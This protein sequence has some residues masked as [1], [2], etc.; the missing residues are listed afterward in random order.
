MNDDQEEKLHAALAT[1]PDE[2][3]RCFLLR[4]V[5]GF[6]ETEIAVLMKLRIETVRLRLFQARG[7]LGVAGVT[8]REPERG[9]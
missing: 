9:S 2:M 3:R 7:R 8:V 5:Q 6:D 4:Y 1:L